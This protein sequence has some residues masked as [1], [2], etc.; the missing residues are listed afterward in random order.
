MSDEVCWQCEPSSSNPRGEGGEREPGWCSRCGYFF[1]L[2]GMRL[3][4]PW[5]TCKFHSPIQASC[6]HSRDW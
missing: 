3:F 5:I 4:A 6:P 2:Y 1:D